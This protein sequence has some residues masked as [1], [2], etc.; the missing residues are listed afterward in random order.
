MIDKIPDLLDKKF[1]VG[2]FLPFLLFLV[3]SISV[4]EGYDIQNQISAGKLTA[5]ESF[6]NLFE[7]NSLEILANASLVVLFSWIGGIILVAINRELIRFAEGYGDRNPLKM[8]QPIEDF[9]FKRL[10]NRIDSLEKELD[11]HEEENRDFPDSL[12]QERRIKHTLRVERFPCRPPLLPTSF[13]NVMRAFEQYPRTMY[14]VDAIIS[15]ERLLSVI[16]GDYRDFMDDAKSHVNFWLN[17]W[18]LLFVLLFEYLALAFHYRF[19]LFSWPWQ[20]LFALILFFTALWFSFSRTVASAQR[21]GKFVKSAFDLY[22]PD[23]RR[24]LHFK[25]PTSDEEA[26]KQW[27]SFNQAIVY[28]IPESLPERDYD[29]VGESNK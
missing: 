13:G 18:Y 16:P 23:L 10:Q 24:A 1:A 19:S 3:L 28:A 15:W 2:F 27:Q 9:W 25:S 29:Q 22:L 21:Y 11:K 8:L 7:K 14:G 6:F 5:Q 17:I 12:K 26:R 4:F 20:L